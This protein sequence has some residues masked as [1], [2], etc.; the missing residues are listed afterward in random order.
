[1]RKARQGS[2]WAWVGKR[3]WLLLRICLGLV[4]GAVLLDRVVMPRVVHHGADT[5]VPSVIDRTREDAERLLRGSS[6]KLGTIQEAPHP[7]IVAGQVVSQEPPAGTN[8]RRGRDVHLLISEGT[9]IRTVPPLTGKTM[10]HAR[11]ELTQR[12]LL[13]GEVKMLKGSIYPA[14]EIVAVSP[15]AGEAPDRNGRVDLLVSDGP[16]RELFLMP[17]MRR[18]RRG[19][20]AAHLRSLGIRVSTPDEEG[21]VVF[22]D[23]PPRDPIW[24]GSLVVLD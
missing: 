9:P 22:Q 8:V 21:R 20:A 19:E 11:V 10:R 12:G 15:A 16:K 2:A 14:G 23:P 1:M 18:L 3:V 6:L 7:E 5:V 17:D 13:V 4:L 24:T